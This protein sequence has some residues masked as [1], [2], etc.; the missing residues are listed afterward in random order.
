MPSP[1]PGVDPHIE[2]HRWEGFHTHFLMDATYDGLGYDYALDYSQPV[3]P[4][5]FDADLAWA[6]QILSKRAQ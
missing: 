1:F 4:P 5:L 6:R 2:P 3:V